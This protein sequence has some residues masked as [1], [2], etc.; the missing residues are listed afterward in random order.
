[1]EGPNFRSKTCILSQSSPVHCLPSSSV[2][3]SLLFSHN[4]PYLQGKVFCSSFHY[5]LIN[6]LL[7]LSSPRVMGKV[8]VKGRLV[9]RA[10]PTGFH[11]TGKDTSP[12]RSCSPTD[13][14][15]TW[16]VRAPPC[17]NPD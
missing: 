13:M 11:Q 9:S 3:P 14:C 12:V 5:S 16:R 7:I 1:M 10:K 4:H 2:S 17:W 8:G 15:R 6:P